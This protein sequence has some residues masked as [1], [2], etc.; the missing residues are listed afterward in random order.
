MSVSEGSPHWDL[1]SSLF[2]T[3]FKK[4][5]T[6]YPSESIIPDGSAGRV[7][8][9]G[10]CLWL[11]ADSLTLMQAQCRQDSCRGHVGMTVP[12]LEVN[13][14]TARH[15]IFTLCSFCF[16]FLYVPRDSEKILQMSYLALNTEQSLILGTLSSHESAFCTVHCLGLLQ[17]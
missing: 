7:G 15:S 2:G 6:I 17:Q 8:P 11:V 9:R 13:I 12:C 10:P 4:T 14:F 3:Q 5:M 16:L 1:V